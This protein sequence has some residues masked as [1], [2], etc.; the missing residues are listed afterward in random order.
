MG[1]LEECSQRLLGGFLLLRRQCLEALLLA[2]T[3][4]QPADSVHEQGTVE[5]RQE[6]RACYTG[7]D[8]QEQEETLCSWSH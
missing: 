2:V 1:P 7:P 8:S 4:H 5:I 6:Q 3:R